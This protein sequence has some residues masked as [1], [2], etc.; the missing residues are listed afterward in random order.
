M[1]IQVMEWRNSTEDSYDP[2]TFGSFES[3]STKFRNFLARTS[4]YTSLDFDSAP[5]TSIRSRRLILIED[6]PNLHHEST[7]EAFHSSLEDFVQTS[8]TFSCPLVLI[9]S[10]DGIRGETDSDA[11]RTRGKSDSVSIRTVL[12]KSLQESPYV[13]TIPSVP[14]RSTPL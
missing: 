3:L 7:K 1:G 14:L 12:S 5:S 6:L 8:V 9:V 13:T 4:T 2:D 11:Q 10:D